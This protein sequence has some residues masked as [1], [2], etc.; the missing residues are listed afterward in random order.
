[1]SEIELHRKL[2]GDP[3]R[4]R[5]LREALRRVIKP[6]VTTV[7]DLGA[8]TGFLSFLARRLGARQCH[9][10]EY[11]GALALA[12]QLARQNRLTGLSWTQAHSTAVR[13]PPK[14]D[15]VISETL[16]HYALEEGLLETL[17]DARR[18]L[19]P[20]GVM[21]PCELRQY[22]APVVTPRLQEALDVWPRV[23]PELDFSAARTVSLNNLYV[24]TVQRTDLPG[25]AATRRWDRL[26]FGPG[27]DDE[28]P[29][30]VRHAT[31]QWSIRETGDGRRGTEPAPDSRP[32]TPAVLYGFALWWEAE[33]VPGIVLSTSPWAAATHWEQ[34]YLPLLEAVQLETGDELE[35]RLGSD[36]R[37]SA[38]LR[39]TWQARLRRKGRTVA[40]Q[41]QDLKFGRL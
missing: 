18:F 4:N 22:V 11:S 29:S 38:G 35:V 15:V 33:L 16:G 36:T 40:S 5:A 26:V 8:G 39:V 3:V 21:I 9:L 31:V 14:V 12:K 24:R 37:R 19:K 13:K 20:G 28:Q 30:S 7:A 27:P 34:V 25:P 41:N 2:L 10:Y 17:V 23:D 6:G 1:M 32:L